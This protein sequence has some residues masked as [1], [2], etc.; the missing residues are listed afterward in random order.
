MRI[1]IKFKN[2]NQPQQLIIN[3]VAAGFLTNSDNK[4]YPKN[5][6][7]IEKCKKNTYLLYLKIFDILTVVVPL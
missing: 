6:K 3:K 7:N 1:I 2:I 4:F 5:Y